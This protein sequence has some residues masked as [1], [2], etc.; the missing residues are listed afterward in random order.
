MVKRAPKIPLGLSALLHL[1]VGGRHLLRLWDLWQNQGASGQG[2]VGRVAVQ[3]GFS[4]GCLIRLRATRRGPVA[5]FVLRPILFLMVLSLIT[6]RLPNGWASAFSGCG[7]YRNPIE[8]VM[9][10][11]GLPTCIAMALA[12]YFT[13]AGMWWLADRYRKTPFLPKTR[14]HL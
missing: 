3:F 12:H 6:D 9:P 11:L 5:S 8:M 13:F 7:S 14:F 2:Q 4:F 1:R 10:W